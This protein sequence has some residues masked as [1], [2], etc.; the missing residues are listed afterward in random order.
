MVWVSEVVILFF[1]IA[2]RPFQMAY[3]ELSTLFFVLGA[4]AVLSSL[5]LS[6]SLL[7]LPRLW[8]MMFEKWVST[9]SGR[10]LF[11]GA[12]I[13]FIGLAFFL[14]K[15]AF[16]FYELSPKHLLTGA[17]ALG[18]FLLFPLGF[19][20]W[21]DQEVKPQPAKPQPAE[22]PKQVLEALE[23]GPK[24]PK[25]DPSQL[26]FVYSDKNY[27]VWVCRVDGEYREFRVRETLAS[28]EQRLAPDCHVLRCHRAYL[29]NTL[30]VQEVVRVGSAFQLKLQGGGEGVPLS[31]KYTHLFR[32]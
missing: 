28:V 9:K 10:Q 8:P 6:S 18:S 7:M 27:V 26:M 12:I 25:I 3:Y 30:K 17:L 15:V 32:D 31:R 2:F 22:P 24:L 29:V 23:V 1:Y 21:M 4:Y 14:F 20:K 13:A 19:L 16:G 11:T 5:V